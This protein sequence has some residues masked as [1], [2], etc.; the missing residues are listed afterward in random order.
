MRLAALALALP[1]LAAAAPAARDRSAPGSTPAPRP[2]AAGSLARP[3]RPAAG[4]AIEPEKPRS[5]PE[6]QAQAAKDVATVRLALTEVL[7]RMDDARHERDLEKLICADEKLQ[8]LKVFLTVS[9]RAETALAEALAKAD[10]GAEVEASKISIA[11]AKVNLLRNE[12][13]ACIGALAW[14]VGQGTQVVVEEPDDR[15]GR[16]AGERIEPR[17]APYRTEFGIP[18]SA[19]AAR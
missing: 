13:A 3:D 18:S 11:A 16:P 5:G 6:L 17:L 9:E 14:Q 2:A 10:P 1:L 8:R 12:A 7:A 4:A 19:A 15:G